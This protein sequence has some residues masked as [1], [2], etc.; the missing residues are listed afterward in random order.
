M[1]KEQQDFF[2]RPQ[3]EQDAFLS[4]TWC[5]E[6]MEADLGMTDPEE[7]IL[8]GNRYVEGKCKRCGTS[9]VTELVDEDI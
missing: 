1:S 4:Q 8:D 9:I 5:N 3:E 7:Y 2:S 6:C